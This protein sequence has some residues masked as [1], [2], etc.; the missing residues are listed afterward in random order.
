MNC[1]YEIVVKIFNFNYF[2]GGIMQEHELAGKRVS[3]N[4]KIPKTVEDAKPMEYICNM[5]DPK[6]EGAIQVDAVADGKKA[7]IF[8][9][10]G[11]DLPTMTKMFGG[12][13]VF[14]QSR[15][16]MKIKLQSNMRNY[17]KAGID[18]QILVTKH[19]PGVPMER[20][21][22]DM[23]KATETYFKG[24]SSKE[25]DALIKRMIENKVGK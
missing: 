3:D 4:V 17:I 23:N 13:V 14:S 8:F 15:G 2:F 5:A 11:K 10:F 20:A 12:D 18:P 6:I 16:Q 21:P 7:T 1:Y 19:V 25:Q 24:L 9:N 22:V